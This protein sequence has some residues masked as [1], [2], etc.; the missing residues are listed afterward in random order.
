MN[1]Q[2]LYRA[3]R[4]QDFDE[5]AGQEPI[6][7]TLENAI[8][9][10]RVSHAYLFTGPKGTGKTSAARILAKAL[11]CSRRE[12]ARPCGE[13]ESCRTITSGNALD[14]V[15][16]DAASNRGIDDMRELK[17]K[18]SFLPA[19]GRYRVY[20]VD[21][22][23]MLTT[24]AFNALLKTLEEPPD[25][26][27]FVLATTDPQ[28]M[29]ATVLSRCQRFDFRKLSDEALRGRLEE[30]L[31][32]EG[33][34]A[35]PQ[36]I[37]L[38]IRQADGSMRDA[39]GL[40]DQCLS[41]TLT[42]VT[43]EDACVILGLVRQDELASLYSALAGGDAVSLFNALEELFTQGVEPLQLIR[44]FA[45]YCRD[46]LILELCGQ[47][48]PLV[49]A[50]AQQRQQMA[51]QGRRMGQIRLQR[52]VSEAEQAASGGRYAGNTRY[53][54]E[55]LFAG[56]LLENAE[57]GIVGAVTATAPAASTA[58]IAAGA[59][60]TAGSA[61]GFSAAGSTGGSGSEAVTPTSTAP[62]TTAPAAAA[63]PS[64]VS[65]VAVAAAIA[66]HTAATA[67]I[68]ADRDT[69]A[70]NLTDAQRDAFLQS[71][72]SQKITLHAYLLGALD[73]TLKEGVLTLSFD[74]VKGKF[75]MERCQEKENLDMLREA[76][77][78]VLGSPAEVH[79]VL[80]SGGV[81]KD[82]VD[83]AIEIFGRDAVKIV[84]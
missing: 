49:S 82:P 2:V 39:I 76:I 18:I 19:L 16:I 45:G 83:K 34:Q 68:A 64:D 65:A 42:D 37:A 26:V 3:W 29:P 48:T 61:L 1:N 46:L 28:K 70:S 51:E 72:K 27:V 73:M 33:R 53:M 58:G 7:R 32:G 14:V 80:Q 15:E 56:L 81:Q 10:D 78:Q 50:A 36:A 23:H 41:Y 12:G 6:R 71:I 17:E 40:L 38:I 74:P 13:C 77:S 63:D 30:I 47:D 66:E 4:P 5:L 79:C 59:V 57:A 60:P 21:E 25:H 24:E 55:A 67:I 62:A 8:I 54:A 52:M 69:P 75:H 44:E 43:V 9:Q 22:A 84:P 31:A 11:N 35:Q 20:I